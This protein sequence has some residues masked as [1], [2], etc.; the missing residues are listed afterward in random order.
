MSALTD[1]QRLRHALHSATLI[2]NEVA[3]RGLNTIV[4]DP[5]LYAGVERHLANIGEAINHLTPAFKDA[6]PELQWRSIV[7]FGNFLVHEY[8]A[9]DVSIVLDVIQT[10]LPQ[11]VSAITPLINT[12]N[13]D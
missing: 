8:F 1:E 7:R 3:V 2:L 12:N 13:A 10:K 11:L 6:H 9:V 4:S 5:L